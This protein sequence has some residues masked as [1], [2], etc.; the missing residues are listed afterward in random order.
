MFGRSLEWR[1]NFE[2]MVK[3]FKIVS[4][5]LFDKNYNFKNW[6][7]QQLFKVMS[8]LYKSVEMHM[9]HNFTWYYN[10]LS[11]FSFSEENYHCSILFQQYLKGIKWK[12]KNSYLHNNTIWE[13]GNNF[14]LVDNYHDRLLF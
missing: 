3:F 13:Q 10:K 2:A 8:E 5:C 7:Y 11:Y 12:K 1:T 4:M 14:W 6:I 9:F